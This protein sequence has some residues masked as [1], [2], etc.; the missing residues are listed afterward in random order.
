M[1]VLFMGSADFAC[2]SLDAILS[3][4]S[5]DVVGVISQAQKPTGRGRNVT[6]SPVA[7]H[8]SGS[9]VRLI[10][11][12]NVNSSESVAQLLELAP[13]LCIVVA[14]G[15]ILRQ[16]VLDLPP[17]G[18]IN[19]HA[20]LLPKYRGAAPIQWA[21]ANGEKVTGVTAMYMDEHMDEGDIILQKQEPILDGD[22][23]GSLHDRLALAGAGLLMN[24]IRMVSAGKQQRIPQDD[25]LATYAPKLNKADGRILWTLSATEIRNRIRGF[26]P[27]PCCFCEPSAGSEHFLKVHEAAVEAAGSGR[28]GEVLDWS[29]PGPLIKASVDAVRLLRVQPEGKQVMNGAAYVLGRTQTDGF[30]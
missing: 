1:R 17:L 4:R 7:K 27:W 23:G 15:Q 10:T 14:Y 16:P 22:T 28:P 29:S 20:S 12:T 3:D 2:P 30:G 9:K 18:C 25:S 26:H 24:A 13:D 11:P 8:A 21:V 6:P 5:L 19:L